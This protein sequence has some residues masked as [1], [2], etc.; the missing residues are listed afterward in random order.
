MFE[1]VAEGVYTTHRPQRF[2]GLETGTRMNVVRMKAGGLFV[3]CPVELDDATRRAVAELGEVRAIVASSLFHHLYV[4]QWMDAFPDAL[5]CGCPGLDRKRPD[6]GFD[7]IIGDDVPDEWRGELEQVF[8]SSRFEREVVF[9]H[10]RTRTLLTADAMLNLSEHPSLVTRA[11]AFAMGNTAPGKGY[12]EYV[13]VRHYPIARR[14][15]DRILEWD[16]DRVVLAHGGLVYRD[17]REVL[18]EAYAW[19]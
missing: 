8:F 10:P 7:R 13:A 1:E 3:H 11:C 15:V 17:G 5:A 18:R 19:L 4:G 16:I 6:L 2:W 9:F 14:Q 12:L